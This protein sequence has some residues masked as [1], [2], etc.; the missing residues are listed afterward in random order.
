MMA[1]AFP[2]RI[3]Q[4][5][6]LPLNSI[7]PALGFVLQPLLALLDIE[8]GYHIHS[9][10]A[11]LKETVQH[12]LHTNTHGYECG[13]GDA[14]FILCLESSAG[15]IFSDIKRGS[16]A[17]PD[18]GATLIY[19]VEKILPSDSD[20][21]WDMVLTGPGIRD[22]QG[23]GLTGLDPDEPALWA[24]AG[25]RYPMGIDKFIIGNGGEVIGI[26]RSVNVQES[27]AV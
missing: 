5:N 23:V 6:A 15:A 4:L 17:S 16:L 21:A 1:V 20:A 10:D 14:D 26:P 12:F 24:S 7:E 18:L 13:P 22:T 27:G 19:Q 2:G 11:G 3:R 8:T 25:N 9:R